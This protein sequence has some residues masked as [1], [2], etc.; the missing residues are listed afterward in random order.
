LPFDKIFF[1]KNI[2]TKYSFTFQNNLPK[3]E[4]KKKITMFLHIHQTNSED[5]KRFKKFSTYIAGL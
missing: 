2:S 4:F 1:E 3:L 5:I